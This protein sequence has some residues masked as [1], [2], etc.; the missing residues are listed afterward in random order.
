MLLHIKLTP[1]ASRNRVGEP[2]KLPDG[3]E[4]LSLYVT[5]APEKGKAN[6]AMLELLSEHL[7]VPVSR[8]ELVRGDTSRLKQ[9]RLI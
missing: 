5:A 1:K 8:L 9:V 6:A 2:K 4:V 7:G 3:S